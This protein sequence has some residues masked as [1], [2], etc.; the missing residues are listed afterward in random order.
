MKKFLKTI[1]IIAFVIVTHNYFFHNLI[2]ENEIITLIKVSIVLAIF[3][4][5]LK[6]IIKIILLPINIL[7][8][9]LFRIVI[10][11]IGLYLAVFLIADFHVNTL[12][13]QNY[14][15][16]GFSAYLVS[17]LIIS[18]LLYIFSLILSKKK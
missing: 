10:N 16:S 3:E 13:I 15:F 14:N 6:P 18:F 17:S 11:T 9:G 1:L 7:T 8:L 2:L 12:K 4:L 5:L